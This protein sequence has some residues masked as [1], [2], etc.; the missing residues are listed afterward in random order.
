MFEDDYII[1]QIKECVAAA[2]KLVF[3]IDTPTRASLM[4]KST[5]KQDKLNSLLKQVSE[6]RI[7]EAL[8]GLHSCTAEHTLDDLLVGMEFYTRLCDADDDMLS[9]AQLQYSDLRDD[10]KSFFSGFG[11]S[12]LADLIM[13]D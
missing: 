6:G 7:K 5:D 2:M 12:G 9:S 13:F 8:D 4:I 1:R 11:I 10:M 3:N